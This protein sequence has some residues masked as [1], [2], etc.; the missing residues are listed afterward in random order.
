[1][2]HTAPSPLSGPRGGSVLTVALHHSVAD[3]ASVMALLDAWGDA[4]DFE[5]MPTEDLP[6]FG[7]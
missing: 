4:A 5:E 6:T 7:R 3:N 2:L 1:M